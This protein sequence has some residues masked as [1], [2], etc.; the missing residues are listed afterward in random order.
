MKKIQRFID[1]FLEHVACQNQTVLVITVVKV[2]QL[3]YVCMIHVCM[4]VL[5]YR[6]LY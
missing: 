2:L 3:Q 1:L 6:Y 4:Y 5:Q